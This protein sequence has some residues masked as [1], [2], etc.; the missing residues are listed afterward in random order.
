M[1]RR[2]VFG[3]LLLVCATLGRMAGA[4]FTR[5]IS[6]DDFKAAG[7]DQLTPAQRQHLDA[8]I[9][10][11]NQGLATAARQSAEEARIA[12]QKAD[13]ALAAQHAAEVVARS[14]KAEAKALNEAEAAETKAE[15]KGFF[16]KAKVQVVPGTKIEYAEIRSTVLGKFEGWE[17]RTI[18]RLANNQ[19][20]QVANSN[21]HYFSP[22]AEN[23][24]VEIRPAALGGYWMFFPSLGKQLRVKLLADK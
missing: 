9:A 13:Q 1:M 21:E 12:R 8:L 20:W 10:G 5:S 3:G 2:V 17:G 4:D 18:F 15:R 7:L 16:A 14:A 24:E 11:F 23:V 19:R 6:P 22:P